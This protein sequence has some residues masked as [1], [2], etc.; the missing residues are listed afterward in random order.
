MVTGGLG[1]IGS[2]FIKYIH[3]RYQDQ[4]INVDAQTYAARNPLIESDKII[5]ERV[6]ITD[7]AAIKELLHKY[8]P[9]HL[10]HL[11]AESHVCR[12][13]AGPKDFVYSN[14]VGTWVLLEE[15][16]NYAGRSKRMVYVSTDEVFGQLQTKNPSWTEESPLKPRSPYATSKAAGDMFARS[17][18]ETYG[19]DICIT[20]CSNNF[21]PNQHKEKLIP[22]TIERLLA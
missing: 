8:K 4:I 20:N 21:G 7:Q 13:I 15:W 2:N 3:D 19:L 9:E 18:Y 5:H 10:V 16:K 14:T 22:R 1:F 12:S 17:Y 6:N 11:A